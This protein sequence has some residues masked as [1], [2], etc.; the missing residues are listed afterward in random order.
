[1]RIDDVSA[2]F[3]YDGRRLNIRVPS[4]TLL[5]AMTRF[6]VSLDIVPFL[7]SFDNYKDVQYVMDVGANMGFLSILF[8][9]AWPE[10]KI[11]AI[12]PSP[13]NFEYLQHN[14]KNYP[15]V[16]HQMIGAYYEDGY[17]SLSL[18]PQRGPNINSGQFSLYGEDNSAE[19]IEVGRLD[20]IAL[21]PVDL[22]KIDVEGAEIDAME[23][24]TR[25]LAEDK[26]ILI[27]EF[28][29]YTLE[30]AGLTAEDL[31]NYIYGKGYNRV[32]DLHGDPIF[33]HRDN[34]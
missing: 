3:P 20:D 15:N 32:G 34:K 24:A 16:A 5:H 7:R 22:L 11:H 19:M 2:E 25:I 9:K 23:G 21:Y 4:I 1:M 12:E 28:R 29:D 33:V 18:P 8:A 26:P 10:A 17:M 13:L 27:V 31:L 6:L 30:R 14:T